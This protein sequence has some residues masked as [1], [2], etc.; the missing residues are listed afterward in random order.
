ME[1]LVKEIS[2]KKEV[3]GVY[4]FGSRVRGK[5]RQDSDY[6]LCVITEKI[7]SKKE[8][9][10]I[11]HG[12]GIYQVSL[13]HKLPLIIQFRIFKEGKLLFC[14]DEKKLNFLK[15]LTIK[16]YLDFFPFISKFYQ[17]ILKNV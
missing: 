7:S 15:L 5:F 16:K 2:L 17:R 11:G 6:D 14:R 12:D 4:F 10:I 3:I 1:N 13:F 9:E 8:F